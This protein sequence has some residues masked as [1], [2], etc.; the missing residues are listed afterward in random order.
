MTVLIT[1]FSVF[2]LI[3]LEKN[4]ISNQINLMDVCMHLSSVCQDMHLKVYHRHVDVSLWWIWNSDFQ[5]AAEQ[6]CTGSSASRGWGWSV[7]IMREQ[8]AGWGTGLR[9]LSPA[10]LDS[11]QLQRHAEAQEAYGFTIAGTSKGTIVS[12]RHLMGHAQ[13]TVAL[14]AVTLLFNPWYSWSEC[15]HIFVEKVGQ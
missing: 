1:N 11:L 3:L 8:Q 10:A 2:T 13:H 14:I 15:K 4:N 9:S 12:N 7:S 6:D 5:T